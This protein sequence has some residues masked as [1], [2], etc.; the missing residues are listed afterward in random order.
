M[1]GANE[2]EF[3][4]TEGVYSWCSSGKHVFKT[5]IQ[6]HFVDKNT[7]LKPADRCLALKSV[8]SALG[9]YHAPCNTSIDKKSA[10]CEVKN[11]ILLQTNDGY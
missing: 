4:D 10:I 9:L 3:C 11:I 1:S 7:T 8:D 6:L 2:G 5:E